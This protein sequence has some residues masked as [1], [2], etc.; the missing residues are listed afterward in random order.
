MSLI[1]W[2]LVAAGLTLILYSSLILALLVAGRRAD[3]R[4]LAGFVPDC[5]VLFRRILRDERVPR[6]RKLVLLALVA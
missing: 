4:A 5:V 6:R 1:G 2:V 3:A